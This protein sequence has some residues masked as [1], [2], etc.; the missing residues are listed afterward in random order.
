[1]LCGLQRHEQLTVAAEVHS[2]ALAVVV[3]AVWPWNACRSRHGAECIRHILRLSVADQAEWWRA[4]EVLDDGT[5]LLSSDGLP[6]V[7]KALLLLMIRL[8]CDESPWDEKV[9]RT[10]C[11]VPL[12]EPYETTDNII[13][14]TPIESLVVRY[15]NRKQVIL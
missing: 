7:V 10:M 1:M 11:P 12:A 13:I 3:L 9:T 5:M 15:A 6:H 14:D 8:Y 4:W 2:I